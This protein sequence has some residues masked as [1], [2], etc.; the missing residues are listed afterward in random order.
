MNREIWSFEK[1]KE[2][3]VEKGVNF[4][5]NGI[6]LLHRVSGLGHIESVKY[7]VDNG[8]S[9][10][11][12]ENQARTPLMDACLSGNIETV[13]Y[14]VDHGAL[15]KSI[16]YGNNTALSNAI[17]DVDISEY[18]ISKGAI[19][20]A[21]C[22]ITAIYTRSYDTIKLFFGSSIPRCISMIDYEIFIKKDLKIIFR[23]IKYYIH[24][25]HFI[26]VFLHQLSP[27]V[28][29]VSN[30]IQYMVRKE[31]FSELELLAIATFGTQSRPRNL[32]HYPT[33]KKFLLNKLMVDYP[34]LFDYLD[35]V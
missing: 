14:L 28:L 20:T 29:V 27:G 1:L 23:P 2:I 35:F 30:V 8:A 7:L 25:L 10:N 4:Q 32:R 17:L 5:F 16:G 15:I 31:Y 12:F 34:H 13:K 18:L 22:I 6:S 26:S 19:V 21:E 3:A 11:G 24:L 9:V 33:R